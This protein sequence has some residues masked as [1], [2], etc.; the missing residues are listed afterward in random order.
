VVSAERTDVSLLVALDVEMLT[1]FATEVGGQEQAAA[2]EAMSG[3]ELVGELAE[4]TD[5]CSGVVG[6]LDFEV[7]E[8]SE[9]NYRGVQCTARGVS[10]SEVMAELFDDPDAMRE[11]PSDGSWVLNATMRNALGLADDLE[12]IA[13]LDA[14]GMGDMFDTAD[15]LEFRLTISA[16]GRV[17]EHNGTSVNGAKVTWLLTADAEFVD[18]SDATLRARWTPDSAN[19][20]LLIVVLLSAAVAAVAIIV[21]GRTRLRP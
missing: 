16:P 4:G 17:S 13:G 11:D 1:S 19:F 14:N 3:E 18:G 12:D 20:G 9:G 21:A 5:P 15:L 8:Y 6:G 7:S 10:T 2:I